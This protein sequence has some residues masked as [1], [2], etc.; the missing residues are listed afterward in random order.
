MEFN[1]ALKS[2]AVPALTPHV[3]RSFHSLLAPLDQTKTVRIPR[4]LSFSPPLLSSTW[5]FHILLLPL[6]RTA[7]YGIR[8]VPNSLQR[9]L[10]AYIP[11]PP[12]SSHDYYLRLRHG[13][14][15]RVF[16]LHLHRPDRYPG[17]STHLYRRCLSPRN[18][19]RS[20]GEL[21]LQGVHHQ[22]Q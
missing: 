1:R 13:H 12:N 22:I 9:P 4:L 7:Q 15:L 11:L 10:R 18:H 8:K 17:Y 3:N 19:T 16:A 14:G 2:A 5:I 20:E 6:T 21:R